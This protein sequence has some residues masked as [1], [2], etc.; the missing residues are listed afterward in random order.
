LARLA[1]AIF[2]LHMLQKIPKQF[3][4]FQNTVGGSMQHERDIEC[5]QKFASFV[6]KLARPES[7]G[8]KTKSPDATP[9]GWRSRGRLGECPLGDV[10]PLMLLT[11]TLVRR[12]DQALT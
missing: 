6:K 11:S 3:Q 2:M 1:L 4:G 12:R 7:T 10:A 8:S 5:A 9:C